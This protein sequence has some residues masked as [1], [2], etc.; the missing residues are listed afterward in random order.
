MAGWKRLA[1]VPLAALAFGCA[2]EPEPTLTSPALAPGIAAPTAPVTS[3][4][5]PA[6]D[7]SIIIPQSTSQQAAPVQAPPPAATSGPTAS[8]PPDAATPPARIA[9]GAQAAGLNGRWTLTSNGR[10]CPLTI[11][12]PPASRAGWVTGAS[13][14]GDGFQATASW[15]L[16]GASLFLYDGNTRALARLAPAGPNRFEGKSAQGA[17]VTLER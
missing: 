17:P 8:T 9:S 4:V 15:T 2:G 16:A 6:P 5:L 13:E 12:E 1:W 3:E 11:Q 10:T 7:P 14:C